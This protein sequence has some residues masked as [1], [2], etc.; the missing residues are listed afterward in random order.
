MNAGVIANP[1]H[2]CRRPAE[3]PKSR[4]SARWAT[5]VLA[6][7]R[8]T[9]KVTVRRCV[10]SFASAVLSTDSA[11]RMCMVC[12]LRAVDQRLASTRQVF[13]C[14]NSMKHTRWS[15]LSRASSTIPQQRRSL[16]LGACVLGASRVAWLRQRDECRR[17][18][19]WGVG[20]LSV[21]THPTWWL[22]P[23]VMFMLLCLTCIRIQGAFLCG[24]RSTAALTK[25]RGRTPFPKCVCW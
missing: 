5:M 6:S 19:G 21:V 7:T 2:S 10:P 24:A 12:A 18:W 3:V 11:F 4:S 13:V 1:V 9:E 8:S 16:A 15:M 17:V 25:A 14:C 23:S 20:F 22:T